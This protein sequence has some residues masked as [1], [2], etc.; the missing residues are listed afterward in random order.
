MRSL[1]STP[2]GNY[3]SLDS[4]PDQIWRVWTRFFRT[5]QYISTHQL[6]ELLART[7]QETDGYLQ[8]G[9]RSG[10]DVISSSNMRSLFHQ[11][12]SHRFQD[13]QILNQILQYWLSIG[14][15]IEQRDYH[16]QTPLLRVCL[17]FYLWEVQPVYLSLLIQ[18]G[19][20]VSTTCHGFGGI[21][22]LI[23]NRW[24]ADMPMRW[25]ADLRQRLEKSLELLL[26]AGCSLLRKSL[27]PEDSIPRQVYERAADKE[28]HRR[29]LLP[30]EAIRHLPIL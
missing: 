8:Q 13:S 20:D 24:E 26:Q 3:R 15:D 10:C 5:A 1:T 6:A 25:T 2:I 23:L 9:L 4:L 18:Y 14:C 22:H 19:A 16:G 11:P 21:D 7:K 27:W 28:E 17:H 30:A 29:S 12:E